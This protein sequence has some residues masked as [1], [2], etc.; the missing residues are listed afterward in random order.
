MVDLP[1]LGIPQI[2]NHIPTVANFADLYE[3]VIIINSFKFNRSLADVAK[4]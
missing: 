3:F 2:I 4:H 1:T